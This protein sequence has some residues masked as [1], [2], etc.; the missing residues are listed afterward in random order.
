MALDSVFATYPDATLK[1]AKDWLRLRAQKG[2]FCP[3]CKQFVKIYKRALGSQMA[4][5]LIWLTRTWEQLPQYGDAWVDIKMAPTRG[6]DYAKT[7]HWQLAENRISNDKTLRSSGL[8]RPTAKGIDFVQNR[9][10]VPSHVEL[11]DNL[12]LGFSDETIGIV[13]ALGKRFDYYELMNSPVLV[14]VP[15]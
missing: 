14:P 10:R 11:Y 15:V 13:E 1:E 7:T 6:G 5:W 8:W 4:R 3:C 12:V 9:I 2:S